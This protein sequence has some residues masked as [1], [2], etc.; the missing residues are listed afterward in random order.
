MKKTTILLLAIT[1]LL[2]ACNKGD[3]DYTKLSFK[4]TQRYCEAI[5]GSY[6]AKGYTVL[7]GRKD[8]YDADVI[9][10]QE[11]VDDIFI[12]VD[13]NTEHST[14]F[15]NVPITKLAQLLPENSDAR[16]VLE[17]SKPISFNTTYRFERMTLSA[18]GEKFVSLSFK[19]VAHY[20]SATRNGK[21]LQITINVRPSGV[22]L[23][24]TSDMA[25]VRN[26]FLKSEIR[27]D[28]TSMNIDG[29][30]YKNFNLIINT[31]LTEE[32]E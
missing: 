3:E 32:T 11:A 19:P 7:V 18:K 22:Y 2:C 15:W 17:D 12:D 16:K 5:A 28:I 21:P 25:A 4:D 29:E 27:M 26:E 9:G 14:T 13:N 8:F 20:I 30:D 1:L 24:Y 31:K 6:E 10:M 23:P